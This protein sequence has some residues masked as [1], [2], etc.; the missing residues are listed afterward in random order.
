MQF[1]IYGMAFEQ[2]QRPRKLIRSYLG[3]HASLSSSSPRTVELAE[4]TLTKTKGR[5]YARLLVAT[6]VAL[7]I[8]TLRSVGEVAYRAQTQTAS[9]LNRI[10]IW[11]L[12]N[13]YW[14]NKE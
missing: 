10:D 14:C 3:Q 8:A 5:G 6:N 11:V 13:N 1:T 9:G 2:P 7:A 12:S 4:I